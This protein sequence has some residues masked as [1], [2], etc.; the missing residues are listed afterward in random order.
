MPD[1]RVYGAGDEYTLELRGRLVDAGFHVE[2]RDIRGLRGA[3][4]RGF[5]LTRGLHRVPQ[6]FR[7][8]GAYVGDYQGTVVLLGLE[9]IGKKP[10]RRAAA[11]RPPAGGTQQSRS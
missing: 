6:V 7:T 1:I 8:D 2:F 3:E 4:N 11:S 9:R 5:L 10:R